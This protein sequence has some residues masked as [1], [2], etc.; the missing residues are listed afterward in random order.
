V[1]SRL[2]FFFA[3]V[4]FASGWPAPPSASALRLPAAAARAGRLGLRS[5]ALVAVLMLAAL[6]LTGR[7]SAASALS[8]TR[9]RRHCVAAIRLV[10]TVAPSANTKRERDHDESEAPTRNRIEKTR[11]IWQAVAALR[12]AWRARGFAPGVF[13]ARGANVDSL[14]SASRRQTPKPNARSHPDGNCRPLLPTRILYHASREWPAG[15]QAWSEMP[16]RPQSAPASRRMAGTDEEPGRRA[17][18]SAQLQVRRIST[19]SSFVDSQSLV[20]NQPA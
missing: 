6:A 3:S 9:R 7:R 17:P 20:A 4:C 2:D 15:E 12:R 11:P 5:V 10:E 16:T 8:T 19:R 13:L 14:D 18:T 1:A